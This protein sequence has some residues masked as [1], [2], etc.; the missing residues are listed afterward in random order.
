MADPFILLFME[1]IERAIGVNYYQRIF[2]TERQLLN[3]VLVFKRIITNRLLIIN[4]YIIE[5]L[6]SYFVLVNTIET[7]FE[8][9]LY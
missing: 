3:K 8:V 9:K 4:L 7:L 6:R 2:S 1:T 5:V